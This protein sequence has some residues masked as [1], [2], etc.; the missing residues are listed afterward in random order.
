MPPST[1]AHQLSQYAAALAAFLR[2]GPVVSAPHA[3]CRVARAVIGEASLAL[4]ALSLIAGTI[5]GRRSASHGPRQGTG[6]R[7]RAEHVN[8]RVERQ[9]LLVSIAI[10]S[11]KRH[12]Q[13]AQDTIGAGRLA[14]GLSSCRKLRSN[15]QHNQNGKKT[16][17]RKQFILKVQKI[18]AFYIGN[19]HREEDPWSV[20]NK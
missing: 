9:G 16:Q 18:T 19:L 14:H 6:L 20:V 8:V 13:D 3:R 12:K 7:L 10:A 11:G 17:T 15:I 5:R 4:L 1:D 2:A